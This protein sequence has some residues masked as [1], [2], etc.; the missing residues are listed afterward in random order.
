MNTWTWSRAFHGVQ[1]LLGGP[2]SHQITLEDHGGF[3]HVYVLALKSLTPF[4]AV[5]QTDCESIA[6][7]MAWGE[8]QASFIVGL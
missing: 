3:V 4:T 1:H 7:A 6:Q 8:K 5:Q 2:K